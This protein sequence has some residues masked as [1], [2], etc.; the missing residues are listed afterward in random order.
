MLEYQSSIIR[1]LR[2]DAAYVAVTVILASYKNIHS[3]RNG[4]YIPARCH[5]PHLH[6]TC[7]CPPHQTWVAFLQDPAA[8]EKDGAAP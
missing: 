7:I 1:K 6:M 8:M 3:E 2:A 5:P 4:V